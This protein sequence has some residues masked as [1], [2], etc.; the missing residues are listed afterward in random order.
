MGATYKQK[1]EDT[2]IV[3]KAPLSFPSTTVNVE[4]MDIVELKCRQKTRRMSLYMH[5]NVR[6]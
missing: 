2:L 3:S 6:M 5:V 1:L 4:R